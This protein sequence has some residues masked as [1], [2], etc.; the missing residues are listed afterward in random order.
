MAKDKLSDK[1]SLG[2]KTPVKK[3]TKD[4]QQIEKVVKSI[5]SKEKKRLSVDLP[6]DLFKKM[7]IKLAQEDMTTMEYVVALIRDDLENDK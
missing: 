5:H 2:R 7:K 1:F 3:T 6:V 4:S